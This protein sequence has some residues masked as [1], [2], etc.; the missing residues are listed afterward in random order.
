MKLNDTYHIKNL[1]IKQ[2]KWK[3]IIAI[4]NFGWIHRI[5]QMQAIY[6]KSLIFLSWTYILEEPSHLCFHCKIVCI[7]QN[8]CSIIMKIGKSKHHHYVEK[9][10]NVGTLTGNLIWHYLDTWNPKII[11]VIRNDEV[12]NKFLSLLTVRKKL[13]TVTNLQR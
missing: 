12:Y 8:E 10:W 7:K 11:W 4:Y 6:D 1:N 9:A 3:A 2:Y 13:S 5:C